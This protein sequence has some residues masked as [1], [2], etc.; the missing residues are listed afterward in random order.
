[1][2]LL[3]AFRSKSFLQIPLKVFAQSG[4]EDKCLEAIFASFFLVFRDIV[5]IS[6]HLI[7]SAPGTRRQTKH[8][9]KQNANQHRF[10]KSQPKDIFDLN[11]V[12]CFNHSVCL[13]KYEES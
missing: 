6:G 11:E 8:A 1:M 9:R 4:G 12:S 7:I 13:V 5:K 2:V 10:P 3:V